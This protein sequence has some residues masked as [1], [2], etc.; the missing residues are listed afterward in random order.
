MKS[1]FGKSLNRLL[2]AAGVATLI[3]GVLA[4]VDQAAAQ[5]TNSKHDL[6][7]GSTGGRAF[8]GTGEICVFCHTPHGAA[9]GG[10]PLWNKALPTAA[11]QV[12]SSGIS[13]TIDGQLATDGITGSVSVGSVSIGCLSCHDGTLALNSVINAPGS[14]LTNGTYT[15]GTWTG[16][17]GVGN[18]MAPGI[19]NL[20][21]DLRNDHPI[22]NQY[23]GGGYL[24]SGLGGS[25]VGAGDCLDTDFKAPQSALFGGTRA[26]WVETSGTPGVRNKTDLPLFNRSF[27]A[28]TGPSVE[29]ATCHD[30]HRSGA[31]VVTFLRISN[32]GSALCLSCHTK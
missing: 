10:A 2:V 13:S 1:V 27:A 9:L 20:G 24:T 32:T 6:S 28:G 18:V 17:V 22:G 5:I 8:S 15:G 7:S 11:Y 21:T 19:A 16:T 14:G 31:G 4:P 30:P 3:G 26:F 12:Y 29:C 25:T 23:C